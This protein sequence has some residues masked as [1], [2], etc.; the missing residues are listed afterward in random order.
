[1]SET[2]RIEWLLS[3]FICIHCQQELTQLSW[4]SRFLRIPL[5]CGFRSQNSQKNAETVMAGLF[6]TVSVILLKFF[7]NVDVNFG[8][9]F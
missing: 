3:A 2:N 9:V 6:V 7:Q 5:Y 1:M 4:A 8:V